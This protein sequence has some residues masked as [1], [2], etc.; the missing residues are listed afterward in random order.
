MNGLSEQL[1]SREWTEER[2]G[3]DLS[4]EGGRCTENRVYLT[5]VPVL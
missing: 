5:K 4:S 1:R 2:S 3:T